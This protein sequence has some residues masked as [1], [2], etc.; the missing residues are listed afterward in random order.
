MTTR[1]ALLLLLSLFASTV[2]AAPRDPP[3]LARAAQRKLAPLHRLFR[4][5]G[6]DYP[7]REVFL[8]VLKRERR[9][10]LWAR[11][12]AP[13]LRLIRAYPV[14]AASGGLGPKRRQGDLQVPEGVYGVVT[15][16]P[17]SQYHLAL[18][19]DYPNAAD[20][21]LGR[22]GNLGGGI[23]IHG[24]CVS[25]GCI[26]L[27]DDGIEEVYLAAWAAQRR[28]QRRIAVHIFPT[29]LDT[30]G[31]RWLER[32]FPGRP[33]LLRFWRGLRPVFERFE[34]TRRVPP[35]RIDRAGSYLVG[36]R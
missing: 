23:L 28:G 18:N 15:F 7:P 21:R 24:H 12:A 31:M 8:R 26:A 4:E 10:E 19:L 17:Y 11:G 30:A 34:R 20:R 2:L 36:S 3:R 13:E 1:P 6:I 27:T 5:R 16:N 33:E 9:L 25:I 29:T 22:S 32:A 14:C 35:V